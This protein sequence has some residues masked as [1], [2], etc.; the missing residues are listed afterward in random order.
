M[1][2]W[3]DPEKYPEVE[4]CRL[5]FTEKISA[6]HAPVAGDGCKTRAPAWGTEDLFLYR[7][8]EVG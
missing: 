8:P 3:I 5:V 2:V 4:N 6:A 1:S 7:N